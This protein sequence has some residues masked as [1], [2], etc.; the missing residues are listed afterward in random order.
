[1]NIKIHAIGRRPPAWAREAFADYQSRLP[2]HI[3]LSLKE[4]PMPRR[5]ATAERARLREVEG[6]R[7]LAGVA[8]DDVLIALDEGGGQFDSRALA[9][10]LRGWLGDGRDVSL[11]LGGPDG[12]SAACLQRAHL[13]W[14]LSKLTLPHMLARVVLAE[15]FYRAWTITQNYPYHRD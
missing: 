8:D 12:L 15:Q 14:S 2:R 5:T 7:L 1:M 11:L 9:D 10:K 3:Q 4:V 6:E 13:R